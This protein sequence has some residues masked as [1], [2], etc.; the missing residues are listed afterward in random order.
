MVEKED[1]E[2]NEVEVIEKVKGTDFEPVITDSY[3]AFRVLEENGISYEGEIDLKNIGFCKI[4]AQQDCLTGSFC[5]PKL[6]DIQGSRYRILFFITRDKVVLVDDDGFS[7][8]LVNRIS[9]R[10]SNQYKTKEIFLFHF[11]AEFM[12]RD[13]EQLAQFEKLLMEL[14][15][16]VHTGHTEN[17]QSSIMAIRRELLILRG[18]YDEIMDVGKALEENENHY[19]PKKHLKY[20]GTISDRAERLMNKTS[21]LLEYA[22][23]VNDA[24]Q[25]KVDA[26]QNSNMQFLTIISTIFFPLTLITGWYGMNFQNMP[27]LE[28]GYPGVIILSIIVV[29]ACIVIFKIKNIF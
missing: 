7:Q 12:N 10:K 18:Y 29:I 22:G 23:Q 13:Q 9:R 15:E 5:I 4:E 8:R 27:E 24:Y 25:A 26:K 2:E 3:H 11:I 16:M 1:L 14:E 21:H 6:L 19:F 17:F 20:F 28:N